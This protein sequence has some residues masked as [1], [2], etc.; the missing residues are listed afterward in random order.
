MLLKNKTGSSQYIVGIK[1]RPGRLVDVPNTTEFDK[2]LW[3]VDEK[4]KK[5]I[6]EQIKKI[7][8]IRTIKEDEYNEK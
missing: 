6:K 1:A 4:S 3:E 5:R 8:S 2:A 7:K